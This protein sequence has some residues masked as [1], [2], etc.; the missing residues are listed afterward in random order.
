[1]Q[2]TKAVVAVGEVSI[3]ASLQ[4]RGEHLSVALSVRRHG[5]QS[6]PHFSSEANV[7]VGA[8]A[9]NCTAP[10]NEYV[11]QSAPHFSSEANIVNSGVAR[12]IAAVS[13]RA[14]L[15]QRGERRMEADAVVCQ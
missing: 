9:P 6:A 15:Q 1:M 14:S 13:I 11:F 3:R 7:A 4:Q 2:D 5:F 8:A 10:T 12:L